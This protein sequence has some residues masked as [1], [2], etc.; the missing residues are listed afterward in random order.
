[1]KRILLLVGLSLAGAACERRQEL[2]APTP[3]AGPAP[4]ASFEIPATAVSNALVQAQNKSANAKSY[5]W[6]WGDGNTTA[7][8][9][10]SHRYSRAG[11]FR[12]LLL[13]T[14]P[15]GTDTTSRTI[16]V[17]PTEPIP[18]LFNAIAGRYRGRLFVSSDAPYQGQPAGTPRSWAQDTTLS[19]TVVDSKNIYFYNATLAYR[20]G[21]I[22]EPFAQWGGHA[23]NRSNYLFAATYPATL[24][25]E[26]VGDSVFFQNQ[27]SAP[28]YST[29]YRYFGKKQP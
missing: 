7:E 14:G 11:N 13:A 24:Q 18:A 5:T 1:M 29:T 19:L 6:A 8:P 10:P 16:Q 17:G 20:P 15:G 4:V 2:P 26:Q 21:T 22:A 3:V 28:T 23:P 12:V 27:V 9:A 25:V